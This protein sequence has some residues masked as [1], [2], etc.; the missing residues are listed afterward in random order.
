MK[1]SAYGIVTLTHGHVV[2]IA[3][4]KKKEVVTSFTSEDYLM[5][6]AH[7]YMTPDEAR[8]YAQ[9]LIVYADKLDPGSNN[10]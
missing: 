9:Q 1:T 8:K 7:V 5:N 3:C 4:P 10:V 6:A 2:V